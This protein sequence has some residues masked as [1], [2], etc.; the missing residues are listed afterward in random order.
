MPRTS[1]RAVA[2]AVVAGFAMLAAC[3]GGSSGDG[4]GDRSDSDQ[5]GVLRVGRLESFDGWVLDSAAAY[6]S[7]QTHQAVMEPLTRFSANGTDV[8]PGLADRWTYD[9]EVPRWRFHLRDAEFSNGDPVTADDVVFSFGVWSSGLNF[10][11]S[12]DLVEKAVAVNR[13]TVDFVLAEPTETVPA[14]LS[15]S[16][17]GVMPEDFAGKTKKAYYADPIGAGPYVVK[18]WSTGGRITLVRND[19]YYDPDRPGLNEVRIEVFTDGNEAAI[20]FQGDAI[21][22]LEYVPV[23]TASQYAEDDLVV[24]EVGQLSHLSLN[25]TRKP[26]EDRDVRLAI[27]NAIDY[28]GIVEGPFAGY[29]EAPTGL[30]V[31]NIGGYQPPSV[32]YYRTDVAAAQKLMEGSSVGSDFSAELI[33]DSSNTTDRLTA[34]ILKENLAQVG[35]DLQLT[36]LETGAFVER[37]FSLD[38]DMVLWSYGAISP[39]VTDP[40]GWI[41]GTGY[42]FTGYDTGRL[43]QEYNAYRTATDEQTKAEAITA[44]QD[45]AVDEAMAISLAD[46][47]A[48]F[49]AS[50]DLEGFEPAPWGLY[51]YDTI[52]RG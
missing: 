13:R 22:L 10:G 42:L 20:Q 6:G 2:A 32:P 44:V 11:G 49:A 8:E 15:G 46:F 16:I 38:A 48:V 26:L 5:G 3:Q 39:D 34:Q 9:P 31:E 25:T 23:A 37:A 18:D 14:L 19:R 36:G 28:Q 45:E 51:Y 40:L 29:G 52:S 41:I 30:L 21:D 35:V 7:Y 27:A 1:R 33:Y 12:F 47:S 50:P 17:A 4:S 43:D 24:P